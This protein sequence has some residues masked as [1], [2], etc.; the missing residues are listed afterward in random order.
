MNLSPEETGSRVKF[1][2]FLS[3]KYLAGIVDFQ[4]IASFMCFDRMHPFTCPCFAPIKIP[5][6]LRFLD[7][8]NQ[9]FEPPKSVVFPIAF[10]HE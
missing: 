4:R 7:P 5:P 1:S 2:G 6:T 10:A 8:Q 9:E 3:I